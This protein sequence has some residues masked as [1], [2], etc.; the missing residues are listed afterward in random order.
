MSSS[1]GFSIS[2]SPTTHE[3]TPIPPP[4][5]N[6]SISNNSFNN[7]GIFSVQL[8]SELDLRSPLSASPLIGSRGSSSPI[9]SNE[10]NSKASD[11]RE[12]TAQLEKEL[13]GLRVE[14]DQALEDLK[15]V[16]AA[17]SDLHK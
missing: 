3:S 5:A 14:R 13:R 9:T 12:K 16:E 4:R 2:R 8:P 11:I 6:S 7:G 15:N 10:F 17:F 1:L